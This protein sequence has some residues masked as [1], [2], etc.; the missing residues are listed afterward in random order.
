MAVKEKPVGAVADENT[1]NIVSE[2]PEREDY[3]LFVYIGPTLPNGKLKSNTVMQGG[4]A[5]ICEYLSEVIEEY[6]QIKHLI[7][8]V[9]KFAEQKSKVNEKGNLIN[10]YCNDIV[11]TNNKEE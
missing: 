1:D 7:V 11:S 5:E 4:F 10:K 6:P 3:K 8:P 2:S 9:H